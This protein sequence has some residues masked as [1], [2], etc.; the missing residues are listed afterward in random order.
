M[1]TILNEYREWKAERPEP[2]WQYDT[3]HEFFDDLTRGEIYKFMESV[4]NLQ[5]F[6][7]KNTMAITDSRGVTFEVIE[8]KQLLEYL[9][10]E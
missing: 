4:N 2:D 3:I 5:D 6:V 1:K 9:E 8:V 7:I 10:K